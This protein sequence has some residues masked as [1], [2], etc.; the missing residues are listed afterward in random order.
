MH[1]NQEASSPLIVLATDLHGDN[2]CKVAD[3]LFMQHRE[4]EK[5]KM[6]AGHGGGHASEATVMRGF[7]GGGS[8]GSKSDA[9]TQTDEDGEAPK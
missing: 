1:H 7:A 5:L 4:I 8:G 2:L 3:L 6:V 9:S